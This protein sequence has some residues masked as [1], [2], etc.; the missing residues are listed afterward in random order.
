MSPPLMRRVDK[1]EWRWFSKSLPQLLPR[2][3]KSPSLSYFEASSRLNLTYLVSEQMLTF[4]QQ[5]TVTS[6]SIILLPDSH[7]YEIPNMDYVMLFAER[8]AALEK[9]EI[10]LHPDVAQIGYVF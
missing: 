8:C 4:T 9:L 3:L 5:N 1:I 7:Q 6:M 2:L 10:R